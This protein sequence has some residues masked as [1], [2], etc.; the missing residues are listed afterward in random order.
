MELGWAGRIWGRW[1]MVVDTD[2]PSHG[3]ALFSRQTLW[4][5]AA[6]GENDAIRAEMTAA[7][8]AV[9]ALRVR[10]GRR[11]RSAS[12]ANASTPPPAPAAAQLGA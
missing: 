10:P 12:L 6:E 4:P 1:T 8:A 2:E 5:G 3:A 11:R 9:A 7:V